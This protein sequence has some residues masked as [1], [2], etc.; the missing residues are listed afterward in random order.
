[1]LV[2]AGGT[3]K[4]LTLIIL[5]VPGGGP[6]VSLLWSSS[7]FGIHCL[8]SGLEN[9]FYLVLSLFVFFFA[10]KEELEEHCSSLFTQ[11]HINAQRKPSITTPGQVEEPEGEGYTLVIPLIEKKEYT[12]QHG[13]IKSKL[14]KSIL[15]YKS[16]ENYGL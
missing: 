3:P 16:V 13:Y 10:Q 1:M 4:P 14:H 15:R 12:G 2:G 9:V 5:T 11:F 7:L 6:M 8:V